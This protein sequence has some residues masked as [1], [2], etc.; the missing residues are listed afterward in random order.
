MENFRRTLDGKETYI[1]FIKDPTKCRGGGLHAQKRVIN[2]KMF[3]TGEN[4]CPVKL[5]DLYVSKRPFEMRNTG[6]FYLTPKNNS[7]KNQVCY[8]KNSVGKNKFCSFMKEIVKDTPL[9]VS[10]LRFTN[11]SGRKTVVKKLKNAQVPESSIIKL[12]GHTT[13][14]V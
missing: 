5:F 6:R 7:L 12:T 11:H 8:T 2:P 14:Q 13:E 9:E 4:N 1:E 10:G 3:A